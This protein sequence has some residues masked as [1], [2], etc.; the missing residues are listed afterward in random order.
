[1]RAAAGRLSDSARGSRH[2]RTRRLTDDE[3]D[4]D[5]S[6]VPPRLGRCAEAP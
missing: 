3:V 4:H 6:G 5:G 2:R 1:V